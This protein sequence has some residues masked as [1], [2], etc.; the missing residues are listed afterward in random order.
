MSEA[1]ATGGNGREWDKA[2]NEPISN[3]WRTTAIVSEHIVRRGS[4]VRA[5]R[6][7]KWITGG[8]FR[9]RGS[10]DTH[11][12]PARSSFHGSSAQAQARAG[13]TRFMPC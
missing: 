12:W 4:T 11:V 8:E 6:L 1:V 5:G 10:G 9:R 7:T 3:R 2:R 13:G